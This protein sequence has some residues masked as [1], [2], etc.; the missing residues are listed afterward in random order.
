M[1]IV[2]VAII[3][4]RELWMTWYRSRESRKGISIPARQ[5]PKIKTM[6]Q[7]LAIAFCVLPPT[8]NLLWLQR[9]TLWAAVALTLYTGWQYYADGREAQR[10]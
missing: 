8:A 2:P 4:V 3:T 10:A 9:A 5:L 7:D 1:W 6:V